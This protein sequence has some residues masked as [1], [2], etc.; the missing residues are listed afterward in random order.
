MGASASLI[1]VEAKQDF[2]VPQGSDG[3]T[4]FLSRLWQNAMFLINLR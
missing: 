3:Y 1:L 2:Q 4:G